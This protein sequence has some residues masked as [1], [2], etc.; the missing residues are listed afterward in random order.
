M[1]ARH[2]RYAMAGK[3]AAQRAG[4]EQRFLGVAWESGGASYRGF[5][6]QVRP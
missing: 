6:R 4:S 5:R 3:P 1:E 2:S